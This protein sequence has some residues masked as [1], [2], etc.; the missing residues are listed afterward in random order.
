MKAVT[1]DR[2][3]S[4][5]VLQY[6]DIETPV[7][8]G[9]RVLVKV[10]ASSV[11]PVDWKIR[12]GDL[13]LLSGFDFPLRLGADVAGVVEA[14]GD[15]VSLFQPG[16][17]VFGFA[18]PVNGGS[19]AEFVALPESQLALKP[20]NIGFEAAAAAPLAGL[21]AM[22][23]LLDLGG[24]RPG[25]SVLVNGASGGVG[26]FAVQIA[27]AFSATVTGVCSGANVDLVRHLGSDRVLDYTR[28]DFTRQSDRYDIVFD[29]VGKSTFSDCS[30][31]LNPEGVYVSTLP[32]PELLAAIAQ[33]FFFPGQKAKIV[34][35]QRKHKDLKALAE[36]I[37]AE[38][39]KPQIDRTYPLSDII[40]AHRYSETGRAKGKIVLTVEN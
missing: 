21:T 6:R 15:S 11:N 25:L 4:P 18:N 36:L 37:E 29:A 28:E 16:D 3:G 30:R 38:K 20:R 17:E 7:P 1:I 35:A 13:A 23:S 10:R 26:S 24:L 19:Y 14:V 2:Y 5:D 8:K 27:K 9:D 40:E 32:S 34:L 12:R 39:V 33:T 31:V 22:Q